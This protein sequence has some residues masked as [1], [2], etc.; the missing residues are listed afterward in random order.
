MLIARKSTVDG[1]ATI[2]VEHGEGHYGLGLVQVEGE[3]LVVHIGFMLVIGPHWKTRKAAVKACYWYSQVPGLV[4]S[5][6]AAEWPQ[7][8]HLAGELISGNMREED[9]ADQS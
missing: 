8:K 2:L 1:K 3:W 6:N 5:W 7:F 4:E 9:Y